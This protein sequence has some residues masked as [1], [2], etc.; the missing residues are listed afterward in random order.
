[1]LLEAKAEYE[2]SHNGK[3][4]ETM[5]PVDREENHRADACLWMSSEETES[6]PVG[7]KSK[8]GMVFG[9]THLS[10]D[11]G[12]V[13]IRSSQPERILACL[14]VTTPQAMTRGECQVVRNDPRRSDELF[15]EHLS[16]CPLT[17]APRFLRLS[18][19]DHWNTPSQFVQKAYEV[20][21]E[22]E[23]APLVFVIEAIPAL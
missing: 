5:G 1:M 12:K 19:V 18:S 9:R 10:V 8:Q 6:S 11:I 22:P 4:V 7:W 3:G 21:A 14:W 2:S 15:V 13:A 16:E 20:L 23:V 17:S